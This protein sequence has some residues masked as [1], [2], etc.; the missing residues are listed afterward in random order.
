MTGIVLP[1]MVSRGRGVIVN[2]S[3]IASQRGFPS[4]AL[5]SA[6]KAFVQCFS[7]AVGAEYSPQGV[8]IQTV[9]PSFVS[10][11]MINKRST[12]LLVKSAD[13]FARTALDTLGL[14]SHVSGCLS[15]ELQS[16][17]LPFIIPVWLTN[18][19]WGI[20][21]LSLG[22]KVKFFSFLQSATARSH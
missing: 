10:T 15:H 7:E 22:S 19:R 1:Q 13:E 3:S 18:S 12:G 17:L 11:N 9:S 16:F 20:R 6:T 8:T 2:V 4:H 14:S 5:Y 21:L